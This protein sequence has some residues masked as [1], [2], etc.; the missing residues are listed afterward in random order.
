MATDRPAALVVDDETALVE[1]FAVWLSDGYEVVTATDGRAALDAAAERTEGFDVVVVDRQMPGWSGEETLEALRADGCT[2]RAAM[3]SAVDPGPDA[4]PT[5]LPVDRYLLKPVARERLTAAVDDLLALSSYD[6]AVRTHFALAETRA[7][8]ASAR[9][10]AEAVGEGTV[11]ALDAS[12]TRARD[13]AWNALDGFDHE[14][15]TAAF[16]GMTPAGVAV[17]DW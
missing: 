10:R 9:T 6:D 1:L 4:D 15:A 17:P 7:T 13:G 12:V 5:D 14:T 16:A 2:A 8:L 11:E 3:V